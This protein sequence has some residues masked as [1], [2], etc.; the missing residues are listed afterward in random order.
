[1]KTHL[2]IRTAALAIAVSTSG[3]AYAQEDTSVNAVNAPAL[4]EVEVVVAAP[5]D[6]PAETGVLGTSFTLD[7]PA[8]VDPLKVLGSKEAQDLAAGGISTSGVV[9]TREVDLR[10]GHINPFYRDINAFWGHINPFYG[11]INPFYGHINPFYRDINPFYGDIIAFWGHINPFYRDII[12]FD[13][14]RLTQL[15]DF[16]HTT[17]DQVTAADTVWS[18]LRYSSNGSS[19]NLVYDGTP[20]KVLNELE[21]LI[22]LAE[23]Q[24]GAAYEKETGK[25]FRGD[26]VVEFFARHGVNLNDKVSLAGMTDADRAALFLDWHD[27]LMQYSGIDQVDHWMSAVNW[28]PAVTHIQNAAGQTIVGIIDSDLGDV[29]ANVVYNG[30]NGANL[31]GHGAGVISLI[32]APHDGEGVMGIAPNALVTAYNPFAADGT[33]SWDDVAAG[34]IALES[35]GNTELGAVVGQYNRASVINMSLGEAGWVASQ[36]LA[37][38]LARPEIRNFAGDTVYVIAAGNDGIAQA[39]DIDWAYRTDSSGQRVSANSVIFVGSIDPTG[40][41]SSFSNTPGSACL[42]DNGV[43]RSGNELMNHFIVAPG[44]LLLVSDGQGGVVRRSGTSFAAPLVSGAISLMHDFWPWLEHHPEETAEIIFRSARD[45]GAPGVDPVYGWGLLDVTAAQ[46]PLDFNNLYIR[47]HER[48]T[49]GT[50]SVQTV[51]ASTLIAGGVQSWWDANDVF[52]TM[53]EDIGDTWRDFQVPMSEAMYGTRNGALGE[54]LYMQ[55]FISARFSQWL[56]SGGTDGNGDGVAG[57][58]QLSSDNREV[59][60]GWGLRYD[61]VMPRFTEDGQ[62]DMVHTAATLQDPSGKLSLTL[63]HGQ[64]AMALA[65]GEGFGLIHDYDRYTGG[66]NPVLGFAS[67]E[68]FMAASYKLGKSTEVS[69][70]YSEN[71]QT[72]NEVP[73]IS[74]AQRFALD[75]L[76]PHAA[77]AMTLSLEHKLTP[78]VSLNGQWTRLREDEALLGVQST[79]PGGLDQGTVTNAVTVSAHVDLGS[80]LALDLSTTGA[81]TDASNGQVFATS[82]GV[83]STAGQFAVSK[84]GVLNS[85]DKLRVSIAQPLSVEAG[86]IEFTSVEVIDRVTGETGAVTQS[87]DIGTKRR[88]SGEVLYGTQIG[89]RTQLGIFGNYLTEGNPGE[90]EAFVVGANIGFRF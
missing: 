27:S 30:R 42:L 74:E 85:S 28:T 18:Q 76:N 83:L 61:A 24:F 57:I 53:Y 78:R 59:S 86:D 60:G 46:S 89:Q 63:G 34:I 7:A 12:A 25:S 49:S 54:M 67:G 71:R 4:H 41:I 84:R 8:Q 3:A 9:T 1:M 19:Y 47:L 33:A 31:D 52:F 90:E 70:G 82:Q 58:T 50:H 48:S 55:D 44:E 37:D 62:I 75:E 36:G 21:K 45:L 80:G 88:I 2:A 38:V 10:Y 29:N 22:A 68:T 81:R 51:S 11:H 65:G 40:E 35:Y 66:V 39:T 79:L 6:Q 72:A 64:G 14:A 73:G 77:S 69:F 16:W 26:F 15:G 23:T 13:S 17:A 87:F 5:A 43:C 56:N 20:N 32:N